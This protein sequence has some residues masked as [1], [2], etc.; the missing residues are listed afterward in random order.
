MSSSTSKALDPSSVE[1]WDHGHHHHDVLSTR[2]FG[3]WLYML[4]D[5]MIFATL[6]AAWEV[7]SHAHN[8]AS[9]PNPAQFVKPGYAFLQTVVLFTSVLAYGFTMV[10]LK[11]GNKGGV[12]TGLLAA[13]VL[14][15]AFLALDI[16]DVVR[17]IDAGI[18]P[19]LSG[20]LSA[21]F[22]LTQTHAL[23]ILFGLLWMLVML[24]QVGRF[25][26]NTEVVGRMLSLRLFWHFQAVMWVFI[27]V[28]VYMRGMLI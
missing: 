10:A 21:F 3:F 4:S 6:F 26:F 12:I 5:A 13:I 9:G 20:G 25:G 15:V 11:N 2:T 18:T 1:L 27:Y 28:F 8:F 7:L 14:G 17:L 24:I 23:H 16:G 19:E 22:I